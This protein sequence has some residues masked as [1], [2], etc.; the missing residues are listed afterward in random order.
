MELAGGGNDARGERV[1]LQV[2][3]QDVRVHA[4]HLV[5]LLQ[6]CVVAAGAL[7]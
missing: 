3:L 6:A 7:R 1:A 5:L 2:G 4:W